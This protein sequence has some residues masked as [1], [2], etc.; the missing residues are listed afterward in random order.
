MG[1]SNFRK[2]FHCVKDQLS[3]TF[4]FGVNLS[5]HFYGNLKELATGEKHAR[6]FIGENG[7]RFNEEDREM[8][9]ISEVPK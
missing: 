6:T 4:A 5:N 3:F 8:E 1:T 2:S 9:N 7:G